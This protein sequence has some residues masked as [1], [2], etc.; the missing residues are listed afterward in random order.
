MKHG[1][2]IPKRKRPKMALHALEILRA[3]PTRADALREIEAKFSVSNPTA[4][5]LI[6]Y[7]HFLEREAAQS[8]G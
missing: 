5:N 8:A 4:R 7:G 6:S 2:N 3:A 1:H